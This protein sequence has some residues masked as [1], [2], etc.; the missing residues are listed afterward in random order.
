M[1]R[2]RVHPF[3]R[4]INLLGLIYFLFHVDY[5]HASIDPGT[6]GVAFSALGYVFSLALLGL[7]FF[8]RPFRNIIKIMVAR[9]IGKAKIMGKD[10]KLND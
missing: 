9:L 8:I 4:S 2:N 1:M 7:G 5:A 6:T 10:E 3:L